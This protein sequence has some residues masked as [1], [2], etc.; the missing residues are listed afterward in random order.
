LYFTHSN[1]QDLALNQKFDVVIS[2]FH[3]MSYQNTNQDLI[4]ALQ[5]A[6]SHL[7]DG[8]IFIFDFWYGP[9]V[10]TD[11]PTTRVKRLQNDSIKVIRLAEPIL[12]PEESVVN[13]YYD[14]F[15]NNQNTKESLEKKELHKMRYFFDTE[16]DLICD[17]IGLKVLKNLNG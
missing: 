12:Y 14:I 1:I 2:L 8:G 10:L 3:V 4:K 13:V 5:V 11:L 7:I 6:K 16:L 9:A 15:I 17:L